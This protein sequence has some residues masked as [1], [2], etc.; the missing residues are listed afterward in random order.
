MTEIL[1]EPSVEISE[2]QEAFY[3]FCLGGYFPFPD[4]FDLVSFH[5]N[6]TFPNND[7]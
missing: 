6:L 5:L 4:C 1:Y 7:F 3:F 2:S